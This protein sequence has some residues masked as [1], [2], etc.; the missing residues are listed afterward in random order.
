MDQAGRLARKQSP[1]D[2]D[3]RSVGEEEESTRNFYQP[4]GHSDD[5]SSLGFRGSEDQSMASL[6]SSLQQSI[7][8]NLW[9][10]RR[11][12]DIPLTI[13]EGEER[14]SSHTNRQGST[15]SSAVLHG[16][17]HSGT[18]ELTMGAANLSNRSLNFNHRNQHAVGRLEPLAENPATAQ[19]KYGLKNS[20]VCLCL[21][22]LGSRLRFHTYNV[23]HQCPRC[24]TFEV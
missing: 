11:R 6:A 17:T 23:R 3:R 16:S 15:T 7:S 10:A 1:S 18:S 9:A 22:V 14:N 5:M 21:T 8:S 13:Q 4:P 19:G 24:I 20:H 12:S 2:T